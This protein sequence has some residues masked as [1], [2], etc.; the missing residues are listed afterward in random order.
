VYHLL[1][2]DREDAV[3]LLLQGMVDL[4]F[5]DNILLKIFL[6]NSQ[7]EVHLAKGKDLF[8]VLGTIR[9]THTKVDRREVNKLLL[10]NLNGD[11]NG[12]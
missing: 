3:A 6:H 10:C 4:V 8:L 2:Q 12:L 5:L 7:E 9:H 11:N 1:N